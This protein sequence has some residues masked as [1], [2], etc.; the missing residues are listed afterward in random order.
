MQEDL[1]KRFNYAKKCKK[2]PESIRKEGVSFYFNGTGW[3][4]KTNTC[5]TSRTLRTRTWKKR[6]ESLSLHCTSKGK[7]E[8]TGSKMARFMAAIAYGK[9]VISCVPYTGNIDGEFCYNFIREHFPEMFQAS[10]NPKGKLF[11]QDGDPNQNSKR[12]REG[13]DTIGC[14]LFK[15]PARSPDL[16]PIENVFHLVGKKLQKDALDNSITKETYQEF[17]SRIK[18]TMKEFPTDVIDRT[19]ESMPRRIEMVIKSKGNRIKY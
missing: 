15:I 19:I 11:L 17:C 10:A 7:K 13:M 12:A 18:K 6:G 2:S 14:R 3:A 1:K 16:N 9:G 5:R 4:H 8:G